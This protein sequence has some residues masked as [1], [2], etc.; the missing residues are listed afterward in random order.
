MES[1]GIKISRVQYFN[2]LD[3]KSSLADV[4]YES[5]RRAVV[6]GDIKPKVRINQLELAK[7]FDVSERRYARRSPGWSLKAWSVA[8]RTRNSEW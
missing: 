8:S 2:K 1:G 5:I 7:E 4:V 3:K 6:Y